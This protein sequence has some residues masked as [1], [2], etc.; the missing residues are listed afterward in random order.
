MY[1]VHTDILHTHIHAVTPAPA[2]SCY[3]ESLRTRTAWP[4]KTSIVILHKPGVPAANAPPT[5]CLWPFGQMYVAAFPESES[6]ASLFPSVPLLHSFIP[7]PATSLP[8]HPASLKFPHA[9]ELR[10]SKL[11]RR[12]TASLD[13]PPS[14]SRE[15]KSHSLERLHQERRDHRRLSVFTIVYVSSEH[16]ST[17]L[18]AMALKPRHSTTS[19]VLVPVLAANVPRAR[20]G[21]PNSA[22]LQ[23]RPESLGHRSCFHPASS[24]DT[25]RSRRWRPPG[26]LMRRPAVLGPGSAP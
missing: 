9:L 23:I 14:H 19:H 17:T 15:L 1:E 24:R 7:P 20:D 2:G 26:C 12:S 4:E 13:V 3:C 5:C 10:C 8:C 18:D 11:Q 25:S 22:P 16:Q 21:I 6:P